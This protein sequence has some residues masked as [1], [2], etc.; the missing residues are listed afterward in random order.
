VIA[1]R[2]PWLIASKIDAAVTELPLVKARGTDS[3]GGGKGSRRVSLYLASA[4]AEVNERHIMR[5]RT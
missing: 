5:L 2:L 3:G 4:L 1:T